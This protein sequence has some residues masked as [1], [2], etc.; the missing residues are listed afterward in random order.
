MEGRE[1]GWRAEVLIPAWDRMKTGI[2]IEKRG[3]GAREKMG[4]GWDGDTTHKES[5]LSRDVIVCVGLSS[6]GIH[7]GRDRVETISRVKNI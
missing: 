7:V 1:G 3:D 4:G 5:L 2:E 6:F